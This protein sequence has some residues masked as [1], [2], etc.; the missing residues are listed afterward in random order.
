[1]GNI[2]NCTSKQIFG[3]NKLLVKDNEKRDKKWIPH[4]YIVRGKGFY[5]LIR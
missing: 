3:L 4:K 2:I 1:M 5:T